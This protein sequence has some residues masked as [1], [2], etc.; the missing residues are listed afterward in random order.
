MFCRPRSL[1][2]LLLIGALAASL[3]A[4][5]HFFR[6][7]LPEGPNAG[8]D[9]VRRLQRVLVLERRDEG[10][11]LY[12]RTPMPLVLVDLIRSSVERGADAKSPLLRS[13]SS[14]TGDRYR[15]DLDAV[16]GDETGFRARL[17]RALRVEQF[18]Q[19]RTLSVVAYRLDAGPVRASFSNPEHAALSLL[20]DGPQADPWYDEARV[21]VAYDLPQIEP[22]APIT[23][24]SGHGAL[25]LRDGIFIDNLIVDARGEGLRTL[26]VAG[27]MD[28][29]VVL[30]GSR[31]SAF[32]SFVRQGVIHILLG[33]DHVFF[34]LCLALGA[35]SGSRLVWLVTGFTLGHSLTLAAGFLGYAPSA[36]WFIPLV[37]TLIAASIVY[38][39]W[40][41]RRE[42]ADTVIVT[43]LMGLLHGFGFAFVLGEIL[44]AEAD[45]LLSSLVAFNVGVE[46]GQL[47]VIA[48]ALGGLALLRRIG[49]GAE[50]KARTGALIAMAL[51]AAYW[52]AE[53]GLSILG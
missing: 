51:V 46:L 52:T 53:R 50:D 49:T 23:L 9:A 24:M 12:L 2:L 19:G 29:P 16:A 47:A 38:V 6:G 37:E 17:S 41:A 11:R 25:A 10:I 44:G 18:G 40:A 8:P 27:Q 28:A 13:E 32:S 30:D 1:C 31:W 33:L 5:A 21:E 39:A 42:R 3:P 4:S 26:D 15:L 48:V 34:V 45:A 36:A 7:E 43:S 35:A 20:G 14:P 22:A